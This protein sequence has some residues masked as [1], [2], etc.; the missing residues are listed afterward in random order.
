M[1]TNQLTV[2]EGGQ[3]TKCSQKCLL[4]VEASGTHWAPEVPL[5]T[6]GVHTR[7]PCGKDGR[8]A[9]GL[10]LHVALTEMPQEAP[11]VVPEVVLPQ[12]FWHVLQL[13]QG[14]AC[15]VLVL[16][17]S[18]LPCAGFTHRRPGGRHT[19]QSGSSSQRT[20]TTR[21]SCLIMGTAFKEL[22]SS[23]NPDSTWT[24]YRPRVVVLIEL[25]PPAS[26]FMLSH[27]PLT[28]QCSEGFL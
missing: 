23:W 11:E 14:H 20:G 17:H 1:V 24:Y 28:P 9:L 26:G 19:R 7:G 27:L 22:G 18:P 8:P 5:Q 21:G 15:P 3:L 13:L 2:K 25:A 10:R 16:H 12:G 4:K 6:K